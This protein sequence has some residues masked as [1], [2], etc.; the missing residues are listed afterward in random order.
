MCRSSAGIADTS[1][2]ID[3]VHHLATFADWEKRSSGHYEP[4]GL[5]DEGFIHLCTREQLAGVVERYYQDRDDL[6]LL[7][8]RTDRLDARLVWEDTTGSGERFPHLYGPMALVA[9]LSAA[10]LEH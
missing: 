6:M 2:M 4:A 5:A 3:Q 10:P 8:V 9:V 7:T 1:T